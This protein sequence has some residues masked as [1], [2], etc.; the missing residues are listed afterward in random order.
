MP[1]MVMNHRTSPVI[2]ATKLGHSY[3]FQ[4]GEPLFVHPMAVELC[5]ERGAALVDPKEAQ[6]RPGNLKP[7]REELPA[8]SRRQL[9]HDLF[10]EMYADPG[11][12]RDHFTGGGRPKLVWVESQ[13]GF[14]LAAEELD[15]IW[16]EVRHEQQA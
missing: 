4:P 16:L 9:I 10:T 5:Q 7:K 12:H 14:K 6:S 15:K 1:M 8:E 3:T 2:V 13:L 11:V